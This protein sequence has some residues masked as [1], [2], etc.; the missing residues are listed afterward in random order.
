MLMILQR[1]PVHYHHRTSRH[2]HRILYRPDVPFVRYT[3]IRTC[4]RAFQT[5]RTCYKAIRYLQQ[6]RSMK[7]SV[8]LFV[9]ERIDV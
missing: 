7:H 9:M 5:H 3:C 4:T 8:V 6:T 2:R 1:Q